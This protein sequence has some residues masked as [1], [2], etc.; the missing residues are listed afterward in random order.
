MNK[1]RDPRRDLVPSARRLGLVL[2]AAAGSLN[3]VLA[4]RTFWYLFHSITNVP[5]SDQWVML[6]E[7]WKRRAGLIGGWSYLWSPYWGQRMLLPRLCFLFSVKYL[8]YA[9][10]PF[11]LTNVVAQVGML[12][13]LIWLAHRL[14]P[15][16]RLLFWLSAVALA[17]LL[18]SSLQMEIF[19]EGIEIQYTMGYASSVAAICL[20]G[21]T[22]RFWIPCVLA[23]IS[24]L[25][26][27]VGPMVWPIMAVECWLA[28]QKRRASALGIVTAAVTV[29]YSI[30]YT[31]PHIGMGI[32]GILHHPWQAFRITGL[33][34]GGPVSL[35]SRPLGTLAGGLGMACAAAI[36]GY[37]WRARAK[38]PAALI[39][40]FVACFMWGSAAA[41]AFGRLSP[42]W[43]ASYSGQ[44]LPSRYLAPTFVFWAALFAAALACWSFG[45]LARVA[46]VAVSTAVLILTF[47]TW[48]WQWRMPREWASVSQG[49]DAIAS[50][51]FLPVSDQQYMARIFPE[52]DLRTRMVEYMRQEH[53]SVFAEPRAHWLGK[54][55]AAVAP[56][57]SRHSCQ[58]NVRE[59]KPLDARPPAYRIIGS[60]VLDG[61]APARRLDVL[62]ANAEGTVVGL[63]RTLPA[64]SEGASATD[65]FGYARQWPATLRLADGTGCELSLPLPQS[66]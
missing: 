23:A 39:F 5:Y 6:E 61:R 57:S 28:G 17:H 7:I 21:A 37:T 34:L 47:G 3:C 29:A 11:I 14:F 8:H 26:L 42:E 22:R 31:R 38:R 64:Q 63:A 53:L 2:I 62:M 41:I 33:V 58:A 24:T 66:R 18:L 30:G 19:I 44:P 36:L 20:L 13:V 65:F 50:G 32:S 43:L 4:A 55:I 51:F 46:T 48:N 35:Y 49:F 60:L 25:C 45:R 54:Q 10:L 56:A 15:V 12:G 52:E 1:A 16:S 9:M 40:S 27:A 59:A